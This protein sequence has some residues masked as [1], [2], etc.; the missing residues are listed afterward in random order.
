MRRLITLL[1]LSATPLAAQPTVAPGMTRAQVVEQLGAPAFER[2]SG[3]A[4]FL[5]YQNGCERRCGMHDVVVLEKGAVVDAIFRSAKR[6]YSGDSS[7]P[8]MIPA[9]EAM[10]AKPTPPAGADAPITIELKGR[11]PSALS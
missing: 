8:R 2:A 3:E 9:A 7:S 10:K 6:R 11:K 4:T 1:V 5:F